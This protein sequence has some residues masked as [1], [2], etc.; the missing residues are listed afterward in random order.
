ML[1]SQYQSRDIWFL[2]TNFIYA[3]SGNG[4]FCESIPE[5]IV[6][7]N[8][9]R[10]YAYLNWPTFHLHTFYIELFLKAKD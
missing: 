1:N 4:G 2:Y 6:K 10:D 3:D 5:D 7:S 9:Y 8:T